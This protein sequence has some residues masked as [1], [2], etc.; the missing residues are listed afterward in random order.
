M[1]LRKRLKGHKK[2]AKKTKRKR[3]KKNL[4][5]ERQKATR[6]DNKKKLKKLGVR[7]QS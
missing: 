4:V 5:I 3:D 6:R 1:G 7:K 2:D